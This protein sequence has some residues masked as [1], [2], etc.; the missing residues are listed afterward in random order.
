MQLVSF[1]PSAELAI[2]TM[3]LI[4][5][6]VFLCVA[7][8]WAYGNNPPPD[9]STSPPG[10]G[11]CIMSAIQETPDMFKAL[12][13]LACRFR[14]GES[15]KIEKF[16][17]KVFNEMKIIMNNLTCG[18]DTE[19]LTNEIAH[20]TES[21]GHLVNFIFDTAGLSKP[22]ANFAC[23]KLGFFAS[24]CV[25]HLI[26]DLSAVT[27]D[28]NKLFCEA[29]KETINVQF[30]LDILKNIGCIGDEALNSGHTLRN[31]TEVVAELL[32]EPLKNAI[33]EIKASL[34]PN[35]GGALLT[36]C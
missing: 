19:Q 30:C 22:I 6:L 13:D 14:T 23:D 4:I 10:N 5:F 32:V 33:N 31:I 18:L 2:C 15:E 26:K 9:R 16:H 1:I 8:F 17:E 12:I 25:A 27:E 7:I 20:L 29:Q 28:L 34:P 11:S 21:A 36:N 3:K 24:D 35:P